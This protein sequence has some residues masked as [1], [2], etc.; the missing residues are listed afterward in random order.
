MA[1]KLKSFVDGIECVQ[2]QKGSGDGREHFAVGL[3]DGSTVVVVAATTLTSVLRLT[4]AVSHFCNNSTTS[5][6]LTP[7]P[8]PSA[9]TPP[10]LHCL[11]SVCVY[12]TGWK[13]EVHPG[14][15]CMWLNCWLT[16][17]RPG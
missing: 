16:G 17:G 7:M 15:Q 2:S 11:L 14:G 3:F 9:G 8:A 1:S 10:Q 5:L 4:F 12:A 6:T 13:V